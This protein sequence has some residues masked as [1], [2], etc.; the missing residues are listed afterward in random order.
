MK[1]SYCQQETVNINKRELSLICE[2]HSTVT[3]TTQLYFKTQYVFKLKVCTFLAVTGSQEVTLSIHMSVCGH[4]NSSLN[5]HAVIIKSFR[6]SSSSLQDVF[7]YQIYHSKS[8][9][10][11][12]LKDIQ[13]VIQGAI[14]E[15]SKSI[16][17]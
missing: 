12:H 9:L 10:R 16:Q 4:L 14:K 13:T 2:L 6:L 8:I 1:L 11:E 3:V 5:L 15:Q 17:S 7:I